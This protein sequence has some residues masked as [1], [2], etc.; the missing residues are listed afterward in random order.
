MG[1]NSILWGKVQ[2]FRA[3]KRVVRIRSDAEEISDDVLDIFLSEEISLISENDPSGQ[4][5]SSSSLP[6]IIPPGNNILSDSSQSSM[7]QVPN[8]SD[9]SL[10]GEIGNQH[11]LP[12]Q[13][14]PLQINKKFSDGFLYLVFSPCQLISK[15]GQSTSSK[16]RV[17]DRYRQSW[18]ETF[19]MNTFE[20]NKD[21]EKFPI[22]KIEKVAFFMIDLYHKHPLRL[23]VSEYKYF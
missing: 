13:P 22:E 18:L 21:L 14:P 9:H 5:T 23:S 17:Y 2:T 4:I 15:V 11:E 1:S 10:I 6:N 8:T 7:G 3:E 19:E 16:S 20:I 12:P